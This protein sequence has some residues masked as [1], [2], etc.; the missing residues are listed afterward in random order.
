MRKR[1][2]NIDFSYDIF[3]ESV[4]HRVI[5]EIQK[6]E[7]DY[8]FD[9]FLHY[10][11]MAVAELQRKAADYKIEQ[12]VYTIVILTAP[13]TIHTKTGLPI[14]KEILISDSDPRDLEDKIVPIYG[15]KLIFLNPNHKNAQTPKNY[16]D[17]LDLVYESIHNREKYQVNL[18]NTAIKKAVDL[19]EY[20]KLSPEKIREMKEEA[21]KRATLAIYEDKLEKAEQELLKEKQDKQKAEQELL[22][23]KQDK[24]KAEQELLKEKQ[25]KQKAEQELL[26]EKQDKQKAEQEL[27]KEKQRIYALAK[28]LK[29][30]GELTSEIIELTGLSK[31]ELGEVL[32]EPM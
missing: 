20:E 32:N 2:G 21:G 28:K 29:E 25:D 30:S 24:Q 5:I 22:K 18:Q 31:E 3:A 23:E 7:L 14:K 4:D 10:H 13:Y 6:A 12:T 9:R 16:R 1:I 19:I 17:W 11:Y 15:H 27:L 26:K 8:H